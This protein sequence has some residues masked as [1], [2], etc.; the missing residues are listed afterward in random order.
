MK[1]RIKIEDFI[2]DEE[3]KE[4]ARVAFNRAVK[5][6]RRRQGL[7]AVP[8]ALIALSF[9]AITIALSNFIFDALLIGFGIALF[10]VGVVMSLRWHALCLKEYH[11]QLD[12]L[13]LQMRQ[14]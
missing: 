13:K 4:L 12:E 2:A 3:D 6:L 14:K 7:I 11:N 10:I 1:L 5:T 8:L 9:I